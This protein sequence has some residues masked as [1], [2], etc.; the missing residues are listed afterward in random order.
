MSQICCSCAPPDARVRLGS[1]DQA[2]RDGARAAL[3]QEAPRPPKGGRGVALFDDGEWQVRMH[4]KPSGDAPPLL[5]NPSSAE[6]RDCSNFDKEAPILFT[7]IRKRPVLDPPRQ[8]GHAS[9][10]WSVQAA[11]SRAFHVGFPM[12]GRWLEMLKEIAPSVERTTLVFNPQTAPYYPAVLRDFKGAAATAL[13]QPKQRQRRSRSS[14][15]SAQALSK[16]VLSRASH[17]RVAT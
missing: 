13:P 17:D 12:L 2:V 16:R 6:C 11:T 10:T 14:S 8:L 7:E 1:V 4:D 3:R 15:A 9:P 5:V